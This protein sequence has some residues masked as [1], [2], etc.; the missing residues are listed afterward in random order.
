MR[1][2]GGTSIRI[3]F[4]TICLASALVPSAVFAS[5]ASATPRTITTVA[6]NGSTAL[7]GDEG[8]ATSASLHHPQGVI[9]APGGGY[10]VA[11]NFNHVVRRIDPDGTIHRVAG[12]GTQ[13]LS[14]DGG[15]ATAARLNYPRGLALES[16]G[17]LL[18][19]DTNNSRIRRVAPD[20]TISTFAGTTPGFSG[21]GGEATAAQLCFAGDVAVA[22]DGSVL[23]ADTC[24]QRIRRVD[25]D[26]NIATIAGNGDRGYA[27]DG[28]QATVATLGQ[29]EGVA[30][31]PD[32]GYVIADSENNVV[33][34]V[35]LGKI[36]TVA[37]TGTAGFSGDGGLATAAKLSGPQG[38]EATGD[39]TILIPDTGNHRVRAVA[40]DG[41]ITTLAGNG[42]SGFSGDG[43]PAGAAQL[44]GPYAA[45]ELPDGD[46]LTADEG[47]NRIRRVE[48]PVVPG[49][50]FV[51]NSAADT[52]D[53]TCS[54]SPGN[55][56]L[57]EAIE[58]ANG[59]ADPTQAD[60]ISFAIGVGGLQTITV[61]ASPLPAIT[62][63]VTI[64]GATQPGYVQGGAPQIEVTRA[65]RGGT[66]LDLRAPATIRALAISQFST[67][68]T[69]SSGPG[70]S[71]VDHTYVGTT[72]DG[73][74]AKGNDTG[75]DVG[76][77][78]NTIGPGNVISGNG[79]GINLRGPDGNGNTV[80]GNQIG[81]DA[82]GTKAIPNVD[83]GVR[84]SGNA[85][86]NVIGGPAPSDRNIISGN[87]VATSS[88]QHGILI[89]G[90]HNTV[91]G[92]FIGVAANGA[93]ALGNRGDG[94]AITTD[95]NTVGPGN[96]ISGNGVHGVF[97][98]TEPADGNSVIGNKI[99]TD[100]AATAAVPNG[101]HG[102]EIFAGDGN[103]I[104]GTSAA[105]RNVISGNGRGDVA[106]G[107]HGV[108]IEG[109]LTTLNTV[110][111]NYVGTTGDGTR[112]L[113]NEGDGVDLAAAGNTVG[114]SAAG[115][116][117]VIS[118]NGGS[119]VR[120][121]SGTNSVV[122]NYIGTNAG[123]TA[124]LGNAVGASIA[125]AGNSIDNNLVSG[126]TGDGLQIV[127]AGADSNNVRGNTI[128]ADFSGTLGLGNGSSGIWIAGGADG[129]TIGG[130]VAT[131]RNVI[132]GNGRPGDGIDGT[133]IA[134]DGPGS[135]QSHGNVIVGNYIGIKANG[136]QPLSNES[137]G[138]RLDGSRNRVGGSGFGEG[139]VISGN[140]GRGV[141]LDA[142]SNTV[143]G[144]LIGTDATGQSAAGNFNAGVAVASAANTI[145]DGTFSGRNVISG[146]FNDGIVLDGA[147]GNTI[148]GNLVGTTP[149][150]SRALGNGGH[151]ILALD[152]GDNLIGGASGAQANLAQGNLVSNNAG[153]G[154]FVYGTAA[155]G[156]RVL[157]NRIGT[158]VTGEHAMGNSSYGVVVG[159]AAQTAIG[160]PSS[161]ERN[162]ISGNGWGGIDVAG[163]PH[164]TIRGNYV[165]TDGDGER[166]L[167]NGEGIVVLSSD[168]VV[169][170]GVGAGEGNV[171]GD[172]R[173]GIV[174]QN[175]STRSS[176]MGN[177][178]GVGVGGAD[179][180]N[181]EDG[182]SIVANE[183][184]SH[185]VGGTTPGGGNTIGYNDRAGIWV[186]SDPA[187]VSIRG[188][189]IYANTGLGIDLGS[190]GPDTNDGLDADSGPNGLQNYPEL[191]LATTGGGTT[192]VRGSLGS[193]PGQTY[194]VD[195]Y[196]DTACDLNGNGEGRGY[197]GSTVV[198]TDSSGNTPIAATLAK[199][200]PAGQV[201]TATA[202]DADGNTSEFS[203]CRT[204]TGAPA[205]SVGD[206]T[207]PEDGG[208]ATVPVTLSGPSARTVTVDY[209]TAAGT[210]SAGA[211]YT[212]TSGTV[213]FAPGEISKTV[214]VPIIDDNLEEH[215][216]ETFTVDLSN[217]QEASIAD[218]S[219]VVSI[220][221]N[222]PPVFV[223][224]SNA[225]SNDGACTAAPG[226]C[227]L[228]EAILAANASPVAARI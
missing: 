133:G 34:R 18:I 19:A 44:S 26:G 89:E 146:N 76:S 138:V 6:G 88:I 71:S 193:K 207:V 3:K 162:V 145:G 82:S 27:G 25:S 225:D 126:N 215:P 101:A 11:D 202:T 170:G 197:L 37:G 91:R 100:V 102:V 28:G 159:V 213:T 83:L 46:L 121:D 77:P 139:N 204:A 171:V 51:V 191:A 210:A 2:F 35:S 186:G 144:N 226:N 167:G 29:V 20:G 98:A 48:A 74:L 105:D 184:T 21:D 190:R 70:S 208:S 86:D 143:L 137:D 135:D 63:P 108:R 218:G 16:D 140:G 136:R 9:A 194:T 203:A 113:G 187:R 153:V 1:I 85:K 117:N 157:G 92:N 160:G 4:V 196:S 81:T 106:G 41:T 50:T 211:D 181:H 36:T 128:G 179:V 120:L 80:T 220:V 116:R 125:S 224:N 107:G 49:M 115:A 5:A 141:R 152:S 39:G 10:Y 183:G 228:R 158:D 17:S 165:G 111:G 198:T 7:S 178:V 42:T 200:A 166:P 14:G 62:Q 155:A 180:G 43:G 154:V 223:V 199:A 66:G 175:D 130:N 127:G 87:G 174:V 188:N 182:I 150:G 110:L 93:T 38:I 31:M 151:G 57:R 114:A 221:D 118:G 134:V 64:D 142:G 103:T 47:N 40:T 61:G 96:V 192:T 67:G 173:N 13:G 123:G 172:N 99:G 195:F 15:P 54:P 163:A 84:V 177:S 30:A 217:P 94:I 149:S 164:T 168:D 122:G 53:G 95:H 132:A 32:G 60:K 209:A 73:L 212:S 112:A 22:V 222:D 161:G 148:Q 201:V 131:A 176:I 72:P 124:P 147:S 129:N 23:I 33:R 205:A 45:T 119:G 169:V 219:G 69:L 97:I 56:T 8:P 79:T 185:T 90:N 78:G 206:A 58:A 104:G 227:T 216:P 109:D 55:C 12:N 189:S 52:T 65:T 75:I 156:N 24:N 214:S 68:I 59:N